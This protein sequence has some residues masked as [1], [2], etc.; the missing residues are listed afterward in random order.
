VSERAGS[1]WV[2]PSRFADGFDDPEIYRTLVEGIPAIVYVDKPDEYSTNFYTSPQAVEVLGYTPEEWGTN[3]DLWLR[4]IHPDDVDRVRRENEVSNATGEPFRSE[5][6]MFTKDDRIVWIRDEALLVYDD[7]GRP[8]F[9]RGVMID[10]TAEREAQEKLRW[11]LEVL[12]RTIQQRRDLALRLENAQ[13]EERRRIASD[14]HDDPIQVMSAVDL[15]LQTMMSDPAGVTASDLEALHETVEQ[16]ID[17]LR[18]MV[19]ELRPAALDR[20]GLAAALR[21]YLDRLA[22]QT[23]WSVGFQDRLASEPP[24]ELRATLFRI[25]QEALM[26]ARKHAGATHVEV[27]L[28]D[29]GSGVALRVNDDGKG[30]DPE[31]PGRPG[32]LGLETSIERAELAGGWCRIT[33]EPGGGTSLECWLPV[34]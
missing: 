19:F 11:S 23:G 32:H 15:R 9:W 26:N 12:R 34:D 25:A 24:V 6:R 2:D 30:F 14:L 16:A 8:A 33:S 29:A 17:R 28:A 3:P 20:E 5:Y 4:R 22:G 7:R 21:Q 31:D 1:S 27:T 13:E 10:I 18:S